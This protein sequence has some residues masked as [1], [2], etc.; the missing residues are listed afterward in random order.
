M[1]VPHLLSLVVVVVVVVVV[2]Q[3]SSRISY[4]VFVYKIVAMVQQAESCQP[5]GLGIV[6]ML[7]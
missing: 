2:V 4:Y 1:P 3:I 5:D 7:V 6:N